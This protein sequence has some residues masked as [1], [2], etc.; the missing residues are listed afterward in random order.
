M[1]SCLFTKGCLLLIDPLK[2][3]NQTSFPRCNHST[4]IQQTAHGDSTAES[5]HKTQNTTAHSR[6]TRSATKRPS[7]SAFRGQKEL[8]HLAHFQVKMGNDSLA[9]EQSISQSIWA[10]P[11]EAR[12]RYSFM[13]AESVGAGGGHACLRPL[14]LPR[15][16]NVPPG[17]ARHRHP[18][19]A[20]RAAE[21]QRL[22]SRRCPRHWRWLCAKQGGGRPP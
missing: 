1:L 9:C 16:A 2:R 20:G 14:R 21:Q 7:C 15:D 6:C 19:V 22:Q 10:A 5:T 3:Q 8:T 11:C 12:V 4:C 18:D 17:V 13:R